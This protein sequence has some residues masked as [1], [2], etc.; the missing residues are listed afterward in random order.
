MDGHAGQRLTIVALPTER[1][2][3]G[4]STEAATDDSDVE[5]DER[6]D[7][8]RHTVLESVGGEVSC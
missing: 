2:R 1:D 5:G 4:A 3:G 7:D 6:G 8:R